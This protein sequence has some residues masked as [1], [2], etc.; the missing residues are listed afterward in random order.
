MLKLDALAK[1]LAAVA[2]VLAV[3]ALVVEL[4]FATEWSEKTIT[5]F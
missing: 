1:Y 2:V 5:E 3:S 4:N